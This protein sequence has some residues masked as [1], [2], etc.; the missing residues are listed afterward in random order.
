MKREKLSK[1]EKA[2]KDEIESYLLSNQVYLDKEYIKK[3]KEWI[4]KYIWF[5]L[6]T[7]ILE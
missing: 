5:F 1:C 3:G 2:E 6:M 7:S 4:Y